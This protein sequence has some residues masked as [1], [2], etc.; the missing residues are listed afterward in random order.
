LGKPHF[1]TEFV[2]PQGGGMEETMNNLVRISGNIRNVPPVFTGDEVFPVIIASTGVSFDSDNIDDEISKAKTAVSAGANLVTDHSLT[3]DIE[4]IHNRMAES[5]NSLI[6]SVAIYEAAVLA[7]S[8]EYR[9]D[10]QSI[11]NIIEKQARRGID[12][13]T[14]HAT[15]FKEDLV[16]LKEN[17]R[18]IPCT[19][20]GGTIMI[21]IMKNTRLEN[22][23]WTF[24]GDILEIARKYSIA[25]SL[26]TTYRPASVCDSGIDDNLYF[27]EM[28]RMRKL[29]RQAHEKGVGIVVEGIGH[30]PINRISDIVAKSKNI[31]LNAPY[32]VLTV[33]T[34]IALG[35]DHISSAIASS[36]AVY[37]GANMIT[38]V[39]RSEHIGLP[40]EKDLHEAVISARIAAHCGYSARFNN[41]SKDMEMS[42]ARNKVGCSGLI[43]AAIDSS[44]ATEIMKRSKFGEGKSCTMCGEFCALA[45]NDRL[46]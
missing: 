34:D 30:A 22:P 5:L 43:S 42:I 6:S 23:Y 14:L 39:S 2:L 38:C 28:S 9:I 33:A 46:L 35:Y 13:I 12:I 8:K 7:R 19:S 21:E 10:S 31:C 26:G 36:V 20:R 15:V 3:G 41:F 27:M 25:I 29:V 40:S 32:R 4:F 17:H 24:F 11:I 44:S 1:N 18:V 45:A 16:Q 37:H